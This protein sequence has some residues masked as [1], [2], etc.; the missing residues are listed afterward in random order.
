MKTFLYTLWKYAVKPAII[1]AL[2]LTALYFLLPFIIIMLILVFWLGGKMMDGAQ[3]N[4]I[5]TLL[6]AALA[7]WLYNKS[8]GKKNGNS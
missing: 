2:V 3:K 5:P 1:I 8:K 4:W 6:L 7:S